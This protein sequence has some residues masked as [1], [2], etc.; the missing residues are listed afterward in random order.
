MH[1]T[2][3]RLRAAALAALLA[4]AAAL[5]GCTTYNNFK[6]AFIDPPDERVVVRIGVYEPVTGADAPGAAAELQGISLANELYPDI[7]DNIRIELVYADNQSDL[8]AAKTAASS[9]A[10]K[11]VSVVIGSYGSIYALAAGDIFKEV[12]IPAIAATNTNPLL[13]IDNDYYFRVSV[14]DAYQ[15]NSVAYYMFEKLNAKKATVLY[16]DGDDYAHAM[17]D[18][19]SSTLQSLTK[20]PDCI[21]EVKYPEGT[22][23]FTPFVN[24]VSLTKNNAV[25]VPCDALTGDK[26]IRTAAEQGINN[27]YWIGN[28]MWNGIDKVN[29]DEN[30]SSAEYLSGVAY[31]LDYDA[32]QEQ[33][34]TASVFKEAYAA[35]YGADVIP[36]DSVALGFDAYLLALEAI[37]KAEDPTSGASVRDSLATVR[38]LRGV[39]GII[40]IN[41]NG[42]PFKEVVIERYENGEFTAV[43][44]APIEDR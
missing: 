4:A 39:T 44:T 41:A 26:I 35:K 38:N 29:T 23:D 25:F 22:K 13:T 31:V 12:E 10:E 1:K 34:R 17:I 16:K 11:G 28:S 33:S 43:Y 19:F 7:G 40:T 32:N 37:R 9:L 30:V 2:V 24:M 15:G 5:T 14:V 27:I 20:N 21:T 18:Q 42:D 8:D 3:K 6:A 36:S